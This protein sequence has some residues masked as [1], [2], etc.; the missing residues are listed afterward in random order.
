[1]M[2]KTKMA[3]MQK[4]KVLVADNNSGMLRLQK[5]AL[6]PAG[7]E[8]LTAANVDQAKQYLEDGAVDVAVLDMR[9][10]DDEDEQDVSGLNL[11]KTV[12]PGIP[13]IILTDY[14]TPQTTREALKPTSGGLQPAVDYLDK[15]E[16]TDAVVVSVNRAL[17]LYPRNEA[18]ATALGSHETRIALA[19]QIRVRSLL[20]LVTLLAALG[21][22]VLSMILED[23]RWLIV[24]VVLAILAVLFVG[25]SIDS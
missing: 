10:T 6:E 22:G 15:E 13:K 5:A 14:P 20:A 1:M 25:L 23:L 21:A 19:Q 3:K 2:A 17:T 4:A 12:A 18:I 8:V 9:L 16:G 24:T 7:F 11:A